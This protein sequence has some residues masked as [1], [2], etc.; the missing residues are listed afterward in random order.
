[1]QHK[2]AHAN[3]YSPA[4]FELVKQ[5]SLY[6]ATKLGD[7]NDEIV[8]IGGLVPSLIIPQAG[9]EQAASSHI[10]TMD[11]DLGLTVAILDDERYA[12]LSERLSSAGLEPDQNKEGKA[13]NQRWSIEENGQ[14]VSVDFLIPPTKDDDKGGKL[15]NLEN[16]FAAIITPGL[17]LAFEDRR[18]VTLEGKTIRNET[19]SRDLWVCEA[20]AFTVLKALAFRGRGE[21]KDAYDLI[22][23]LQNY[24]EGIGSVFERLEPLLQKDAT[25]SALKILDKDFTNIDS[26]GAKRMAEFLGD[27]E[28]E[29]IRADASG[30]VSGL[31]RLAKSE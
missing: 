26:V 24:G 27:P 6:I 28:N 8:I 17:E 10:G 21:N 2:P 25:Q 3:K 19:A 31:L 22:Y 12:E 11:V 30:L 1:M 29:G 5:T 13:T 4:A 14:K 15:R 7:L 20:G 18:K 9:P 23:V 16:N